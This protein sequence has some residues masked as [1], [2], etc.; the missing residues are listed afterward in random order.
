MENQIIPIKSTLQTKPLLV[1]LL[2]LVFVIVTTIVLST[3]DTDEMSE[4]YSSR[5]R[6]RNALTKSIVETLG[7]TG[8]IIAGALISIYLGYRLYSRY[9][10]PAKEIVYAKA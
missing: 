7:P 2:A 4:G 10:N 6:S 8:V 5:S 1:N 9:K 3:T